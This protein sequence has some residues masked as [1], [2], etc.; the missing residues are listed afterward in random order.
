VKQRYHRE[1]TVEA[2]SGY[3]QAEALE[4]IIAANLGQDALRYQIG[5]DHFH[6]DSNS[7]AAGDAYCD[8]L[9]CSVLTA[10]WGEIPPSEVE[11]SS[12]MR[13]D[14][15]PGRA[16]VLRVR[17][18]LGRLTHAVQDLYA[19]SNYV[20][21]WRESHPDAPP[22]EIDPELPELLHDSRLHSG[23]LYYPLEALSFIAALKP[24]VLPLLPRD[25]HAWMNIDD[26]SC[27]DFAYSFAAAVKRT[28]AEYRLI[29]KQ[30][31]PQVIAL[32]TGK[33]NFPSRT[34]C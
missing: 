12:R 33:S 28:S 31:S 34:I 23:K 7:F 27:Q 1:I 19:H 29:I 11:L 24:Y 21:L 20:A 18:S 9:R 16:T 32:F 3:F 14:V 13:V 8:E 2:L 4:N 6:Y 15:T 22:D 25:S 10:L 17:K 5:H 30:L 26:P